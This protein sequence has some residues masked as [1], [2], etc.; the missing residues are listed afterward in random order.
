MI[1]NA[2][3]QNEIGYINLI[4]DVLSFGVNIPSRT[5]INS[6]A[7]FDAKISYRDGQFPFS[8][9]RPAPLR[10]AFEEFWMFMR[11][12][13]QTKVL[14]DKNINFWKGNTSREFLDSRGLY[15]L[16]EGD[17]GMAYGYQWR[18][19]NKG[20]SEH[21]VDQLHET[22]KILK[23]D[24]YSRR[25]YTT[26]WN[27]SA[28]TF[29]ALTP[30][31]HSHQF[32]VL[33]DNKGNNILNLKVFNRSLD[34]LFGYSFA[35]QQYKLYQ[36]CIANLLNMKCG[37]LVCDL[38]HVHLYDNQLE[39]AEETIKRQLG[40]QGT[41]TLTTKLKN[42]DDMLSLEYKDF[43]IQGLEVNNSPYIAKKPS[44]AV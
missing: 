30:C 5:G 28:S 8:T 21:V 37:W 38:T 10:M 6:K 19:Y 20:I 18:G 9:I 36:M 35:V 43:S 11:G 40:K 3:Y 26:F 1:L 42:L 12:E 2:T 23:N 17:M 34:V 14:E 29:M 15:N 33:P 24:P 22:I 16:P 7:M 27:P 32:V 44:M 4:A 41:V 13:T 39:F 25:I 31:W